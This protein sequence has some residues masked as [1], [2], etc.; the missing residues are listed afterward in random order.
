MSSSEADVGTSESMGSGGASPPV[1]ACPFV[2][3]LAPGALGSAVGAGLGG[4][5][6][7]LVM[8]GLQNLP[9]Q[10]QPQVFNTMEIVTGT[11]RSTI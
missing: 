8:T 6:L 5:G 4:A 7:D 9:N 3:S 11:V 1:G 2:E 10:Y